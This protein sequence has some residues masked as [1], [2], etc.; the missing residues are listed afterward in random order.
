[1]TVSM[2]RM[3]AGSG[4]KYLLRSVAAGDGNRALS[5][6]L[7]RYYSEAGTP[8]GR[9]MGS[10]VRVFGDGQLVP[11]CVVTEEQLALLV[12]MGRDPITG[13]QLGRAYP[14]Y[15]RLAERI[16]DRVDALDPEMTLDDCAAETTRIEAEET[17]AGMRQAVAGFDLTFSVPKSVSVLW[18]VADPATQE[19]IVK[20]HHDSVA[21]VLDYFEREV[22]ATRTG[23]S[24]CDGA[25][26]QVDVVGVAA[27]AY[28]HYDSRA[29]DPQLH[30][31]LVVSNKVLTVWDQRWRS[32]DSR[33]VHAAVTGLSAQYNAVLADRLSRDLGIEWEL[34]SRGADRNPQWEIAGV[35]DDVLREFSSRSREIELEKDRLIAAYRRSHGRM[36]SEKKIVEL[37]AQAT[38]A[39]RPPKEIRSLADLT[40]EWR[41][42]ASEL[43]DGTA[44]L[45]AA[46]LLARSA[47]QPLAAPDVPIP[48]VHA[49][50]ADVVGAV[51]VKRSTWSHWNLLAEASKQT[52]D[53]RF[54]STSD[55][56]AIVGM[57]VDAAEQTSV[58]L[59]PPELAASPSGF[60]RTDGTSVFRPRHSVKFSSQAVLDAEARL[61]DRSS[62][63]GAP[64]TSPLIVERVA[65]R[66][67]KLSPEQRAA[68]GTI[69]VSGRQLD[70]LVGPAGAGKTTTMRAL[71]HAWISEHGQGSVI[72][73]APSANAAQTLAED[74][75]IV[76]D[77]T[78]KW[79]FEHD[80]DNPEYQLRAGQLVIVDEATLAGTTTLDRLSSLAAAAGAKLLLVGDAY[81]LSAIDAGGAFALLVDRRTDA[82]E[83]AEIHRFKHV[84]EKAASLALR[85]GDV[86]VISTYA[87]EHRIEEGNTDEMLDAAYE[88]WRAD[89]LQGRASILVTESAHAVRALNERARAERVVLDGAD[90]GREINLADGSRASVGDL[91]ITRRNDRSLR[92]MRGG[93]V[94]NGDR[95]RITDI[96][97]DGS[98]A[99]RRLDT[100]RRGSAVL[101]ADYVGE[102]VDLGYA[103]TAHRAQGITVGTAH[104]VVSSSTARENLY[105]SMTRGRDANIA[106][107]ALDQPDDSHSTPEPEDVSARTVL[108]GVL[109]HTGASQSAHATI[110]DEYSTYVGIDRLAAELETIAAEAQ[111]DRFV[112]LLR[113][114]GLS[115]AEHHAVTE[116]TAFGP[117]AAALRRAEANHH[118]LERLVPRVVAQHGLADADDAAAV[119]TYRVDKAASSVPRGKRAVKPRLIVGLIPEPLGPMSDENRRAIDERKDLIETRARALAE[120]AV[121]KRPA[122]MRRL[123][124]PPADQ[125]ARESWIAEVSTV[126]AYRDRYG[127]VSD[128]PVGGR[129]TNAAQENERRRALESVRAAASVRDGAP[130][131]RQTLSAPAISGP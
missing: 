53:L 39:T 37:R 49:L 63:L 79:L 119:L 130:W 30:T 77:N 98:V 69:A 38:L 89:Q 120:E 114:S 113:R 78:T 111:H 118:D 3:S 83:L 40:A 71:R 32:L 126:A 62:A 20:A 55:R 61:L 8:P 14:S 59:T 86:E 1:M 87:R 95:W 73:L 25:V 24:D 27:V 44:E 100:K 104:V 107:V 67:T 81:Q 48:A 36:P 35:G 42:R 70:L 45:W 112:D 110:E 92:T 19:R 80:R 16:Q 28:D 60:R 91:I 106:Y 109:Q 64:T 22:A 66:A 103:I 74:L 96:R 33:P 68:I 6:P 17:A 82:P 94:K 10:G 128:L 88:G 26:A 97:K 115:D 129:S 127:I 72:G 93:W 57:I 41:T 50:A 54:A 46:S 117:L 65:H 99:V 21:D 121:E 124:A 56:E 5:T 12:G 102:H 2:R 105:V 108:Y 4:Y 9:W 101:P 11:G 131:P 31:H 29:G 13:D 51:S 75:G 23:V 43:V 123:V 47:D 18:G 58:S 85:R 122:W 116:S 52:M 90:D 125:T 76:C 84:W 7:T 34:R 15:K